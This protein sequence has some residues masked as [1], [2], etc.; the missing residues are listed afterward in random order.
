MP[1]TVIREIESTEYHLLEDFLYLA[2]FL[3]PG[4]EP[5]S[6]EI[7]FVPEIYIYIKDFGGKDDY[8]VVAEKDGQI[9]GAAWVRI[10]SAYGHIDDE[11]PEL[12]ISVLPEYRGHGVGTSLMTFL[13]D[14]LREHE[15]SRTSL[16]VQKNNPAVRFYNRLGYTVTDEKL[17]H[18][19]HDDYI[20]IK[21]LILFLT[22]GI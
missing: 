10:I 14:L 3:P 6:R 11:T 8:G 22:D 16:S 5:P 7:I 9:I 17:D 1:D 19:G 4:V 21:E 13:F 12:A 15:Y 2:I 20:M 18:A